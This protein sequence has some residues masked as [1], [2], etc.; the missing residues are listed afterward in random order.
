[1]SLLVNIGILE[2]SMTTMRRQAQEILFLIT[3]KSPDTSRVLC[4]CRSQFTSWAVVGRKLVFQGKAP[5]GE[6][7]HTVRMISK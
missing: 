1:M 5:D 6:A 2:G 4:D 3:I 7:V